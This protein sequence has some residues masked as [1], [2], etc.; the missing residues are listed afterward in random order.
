VFYNLVDNALKHAGDAL[1]TIR[2]FT[3]ETGTGLTIV[4]EDDGAGISDADKPNLFTRGFGKYT[5][6]GLF[7]SREILSITGMTIAETGTAGRG[8][9]FEIAVPHGA[10]RFTGDR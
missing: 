8:A 2:I 1:T 7:L 4:V 10:Y 3:Q 6:F 9:R 5:G